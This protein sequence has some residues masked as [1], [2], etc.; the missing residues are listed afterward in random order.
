MNNLNEGTDTLNINDSIYVSN[1]MYMIQVSEFAVIQLG[2]HR[3][4]I[5]LKMTEN[6]Q[7]DLVQSR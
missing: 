4:E 3:T 1:M 6:M 2:Q 5:V 7:A